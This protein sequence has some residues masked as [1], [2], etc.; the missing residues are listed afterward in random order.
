MN[1]E[2]G[3]RNAECGMRNAE[4]GMRNKSEAQQRIAIFRIPNS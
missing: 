1:A 2:C 3:I 4:Y